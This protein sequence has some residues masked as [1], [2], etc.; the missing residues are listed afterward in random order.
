MRLIRNLPNPVAPWGIAAHQNAKISLGEPATE[1]MCVPPDHLCVMT[2]K[3]A[4]VSEPRLDRGAWDIIP[5]FVG[6]GLG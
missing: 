6:P 4:W 3:P 2:V 1:L 5:P